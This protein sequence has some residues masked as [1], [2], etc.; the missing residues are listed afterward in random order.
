MIA[1]PNNPVTPYL[2]DRLPLKWVA[3]TIRDL[4]SVLPDG[5]ILGQ[6]W[7]PQCEKEPSLSNSE[8]AVL[9][10]TAVQ[11]GKFLPEHNKRLPASLAPRPNLE[12]KVGD[13]LLTCAGPRARCGVG[14]LVRETR[15]RLMISGKLYRFR[16]NAELVLPEYVEAFLRTDFAQRAIDKMKTGISDSGLNLTH[17]RFLVL[18]MVLA[19]LP[20]QRRIVDEVDSYVTRLDAAINGLK[21]IKANLKR[22]RA[23]VLKAAVEGRLVPT[24]AELAKREGRGYEPASDLL[25][26]ILKERRRQWEAREVAKMKARGPLSSRDTWKAR[27][28][29]P[30]APDT[31]KLPALPEGWCWTTVEAVGDVLLGRQRAP[32]FLTGR[33]EKPYLRVANIK[34]DRIDLV[35]VESMDFDQEHFQKYRLASGDILVSEGQSPHLVGQSA[36]YRGE[37]PAGLCFQKTLH[38]FRPIAGGPSAEFSQL[39][40]RA[41]VK[42]GVF[43][44][45]ASI[46]TNIAHLTLE[47]F[48]AAPFPLPPASEQDRIATEVGRILSDGDAVEAAVVANV[49]R[50]ARLRQ[51]ILSWAFEGKL[52]DQDPHD[53]HVSALLEK[54]RVERA[55]VTTEVRRPTRIPARKTA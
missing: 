40:F 37:G 18:P 12:V 1:R 54:T 26:R 23:S 5:R 19:P 11:P 48:E 42:S 50:I 34:D 49:E 45:L 47:K 4:L 35:D 7:S 39:V 29:E 36:I 17:D 25:A 55:I 31:S 13:I 3:V 27:Y 51:S 41:H 15:P 28:L 32:Q 20:E 14:C 33:F 21:R 10:T 2:T 43:Q 6:G 22:Y 9:R 44:R 52:A 24:E 46:T 8:W 53:E 38:R 30:P 16:V